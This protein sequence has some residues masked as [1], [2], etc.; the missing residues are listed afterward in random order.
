MDRDR[1]DNLSLGA[2]AARGKEDTLNK[3]LHDWETEM[4]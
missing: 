3:Q 1:Y 4:D 2:L